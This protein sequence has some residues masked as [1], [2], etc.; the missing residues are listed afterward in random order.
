MNTNTKDYLRDNP[1][2]LVA[3]IILASE[4]IPDI[5]KQIYGNEKNAFDALQISQVYG[6]YM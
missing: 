1:C 6:V 5:L 4:G 2:Y 3:A